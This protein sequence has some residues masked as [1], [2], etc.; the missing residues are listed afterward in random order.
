MRERWRQMPGWPYEAS[1]DA[2]VRRAGDSQPLTPTPDKD[3]YERVTLYRVRAGKRERKTFGVHQVVCLAWHGAPE[4]RHLD[5][6]ESN[7]RPGNLAWGSHRENERDKRSA[8]TSADRPRLMGLT[9]PEE[10]EEKIGRVVSPPL[11]AVS[12]VSGELA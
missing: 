4:V 6:D 1:D 10:T 5:G 12:P 2:E 7:N 8:S 9:G 3:G 11:T